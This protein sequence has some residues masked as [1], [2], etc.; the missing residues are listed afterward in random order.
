MNLLKP[1]LKKLLHIVGAASLAGILIWG[2]APL[3]HASSELTD[4]GY[5]LEQMIVFSRHNLRT[6]IVKD[7]SSSASMMNHKLPEWNMPSGNLTMK[8]GINETILG[9]YMQAYLLDEGFMPNSWQPAYGEVDFYANS[10]QRT[11]AT[12]QYFAVGMLPTANVPIRHTLSIND[13]DPVFI[14]P[15]ILDTPKLYELCMK[16]HNDNFEAY[17]ADCHRCFGSFEKISDFKNSPFA[18]QHGISHI[19]TSNLYLNMQGE[20]KNILNYSGD[21]RN[22]YKLLDAIIMNYFEEPDNNMADWGSGMTDQDWKNIGCIKTRGIEMISANPAIALRN[23]HDIL[24]IIA[25]DLKNDRLKFAFLCGHDTNI[26][27]IL[28]VLQAE[29]YTLPET[30]LTKAPLGIKIVFEKRQDA[31]GKLFINPYLM[32]MSDRQQRNSSQLNLQHPPML[33]PL[34]FKG[35]HK[36]EDGLYPYAEIEERLNMINDQYNEYCVIK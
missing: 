4:K 17:K 14:K 28:T 29:D 32:Y 11:I 33:Y 34:S 24:N 22:A 26:F 16:Y 15:H 20:N 5:Q 8:G 1:R 12:A 6:T 23:S 21:A 7:D 25:D 10:Y 30:I 2:S 36:T 13:R 19:D 31:A 18:K 3:A 27:N 9:Q 35:L